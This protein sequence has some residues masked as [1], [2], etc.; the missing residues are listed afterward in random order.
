MVNQNV[1]RKE[2]TLFFLAL[3]CHLS[4]FILICSRPLA[5]LGLEFQVFTVMYPSC[6]LYG[7]IIA[8]IVSIAELCGM[9]FN[10]MN[11]LSS[12][13]VWYTQRLILLQTASSY[14][15]IDNTLHEQS[16]ERRFEV[17]QSLKMKYVKL[18]TLHCLFCEKE[19]RCFTFPSRCP[20]SIKSQI[21]FCRCFAKES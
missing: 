13:F 9:F 21:E 4:Q 12:N 5:G 7:L 1:Q 15:L 16:K 17:D 3:R 18:R 10:W 2:I 20:I 14:S 8:L 6:T 19:G 11:R